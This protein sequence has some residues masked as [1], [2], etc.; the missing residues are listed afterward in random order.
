MGGTILELKDLTLSVE[1]LLLA[2]DISFIMREG[3]RVGILGPNGCGKSTLLK[4][5]MGQRQPAGG[6]VVLG[7][8]TLIGY[9]DQQ[10]SGLDPE[11]KVAEIL[12]PG[13]W[14]EVN[15]KKRHKTGYLEEFL[16]TPFEQR[17][18]VSVLSGGE[19]ARLLLA[20]LMLRGR[21]CLFWMSPPM[22]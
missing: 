7:R 10:R 4:T 20:L 18:L 12:G 1:D 13:E 19:R 22:I 2:Q 17:K 9:I 21:I 16:F 11:L 6:E 15:G 8:K 5:I 3:E 14:V